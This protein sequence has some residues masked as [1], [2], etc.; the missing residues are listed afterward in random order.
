MNETVTLALIAVGSP[1]LLSILTGWQLSRAKVEE[2]KIRREE[3]EQEYARLDLVA[4]KAEATR[5]EQAS[6]TEEAAALL[7]ASNLEVANTAKITNGK[8]DVIHTL[9]N[10]SLT[11]AMQ[12]EADAVARELAMMLEVV[13]LKR[14]AGKEPT[15]E[16]LAAIDATK[17]KIAEL[18]AKLADRLK[19]AEIVTEQEKE[20]RESGVG[21]ERGKDG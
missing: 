14:A 19:Q 8:L 9:V 7:L 2:A 13:E 20:S 6:R 4:A 18:H 15:E 21:I 16:V 10:S 12:S 1:L 17:A 11:G 5:Q 3:K